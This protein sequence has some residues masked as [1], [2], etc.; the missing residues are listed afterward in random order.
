[1]TRKL[2]GYGDSQVVEG[3]PATV[4]VATFWSLDTT[5]GTKLIFDPPAESLL[6][7]LIGLDD[8]FTRDDVVEDDEDMPDNAMTV[9][10][11]RMAGA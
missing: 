7:T 9:S 11:L 5:V 1:M 3:A 10:H 8:F 4:L 2:T 6:N